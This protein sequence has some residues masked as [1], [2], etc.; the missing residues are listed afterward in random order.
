MSSGKQT[1][2]HSVKSE[3]CSRKSGVVCENKHK[4]NVNKFHKVVDNSSYCAR[5]MFLAVGYSFSEYSICGQIS[6]PYVHSSDRD[7]LSASPSLV[8]V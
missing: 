8:K 2:N 7:G 3:D 6:L 5:S 4:D 1:S